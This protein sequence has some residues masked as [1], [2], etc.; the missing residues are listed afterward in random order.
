MTAIIRSN[1]LPTTL[2]K[3]L[4]SIR[5]RILLLSIGR[6]LAYAIATLIVLMIVSMTIDWLWG[7]FSQTLR[8]FLTG[9][10]LLLSI[11]VLL[12]TTIPRFISVTSRSKVA[13][14]V[15][16]SV[17][18]MQE[19]WTTVA[20]FADNR[21]GLL[22]D[23][24]QSML[25]QVTDEAVA[26]QALVR[27]KEIVPLSVLRHSLMAM[28]VCFFALVT[29]LSLNWQQTTVLLQRFWSPHR[30][31]TAT[32]LSNL[33]G[34]KLVPR[35][36]L[37][38][39]AISQSGLHR[40]SAELTVRYASGVEDFAEVSTDDENEDQ[41]LHTM[42]LDESVMYRV[43]AGDAE[44]SWYSFKVIDYPEIESIEFKVVAPAYANRPDVIKDRLPRRIKVIQGT[45][46]EVAIR[47]KETLERLVLSLQNGSDDG[48][49]E[50]SNLQELTLNAD[51]DG[52]YRFAT[53]LMQNLVLRPE[54]LSEHGLKNEAKLFSRIEV[55]PDQTP[56]ARV[57]HPTDEMAVT[58]DEVIDIQF[59]AHDDHGIAR[60]ELVVY[61]EAKL[62]QDRNPRILTTIPI[63][64]G[65]QAMQKHL[66]GDAQLDLKELDLKPGSSISYAVRVTDNRDASLENMA[67]LP[68]KASQHN[69][70]DFATSD[71]RTEEGRDTAL[72]SDERGTARLSDAKTTEPMVPAEGVQDTDRAAAKLSA[73]FVRSESPEHSGPTN[74]NPGVAISARRTAAKSKTDQSN[75]QSAKVSSSN[76]DEESNSKLFDQKAQAR[77]FARLNP[78]QNSLGQNTET[79]RRKL[80]I[81][82]R[83]SAVA[84]SEDLIIEHQSI[85]DRVV[86]I[87]E[88][89]SAGEIG[90]RRLVDHKIADAQRGAQFKLLDGQFEGVE[91]YIAD[92]R[93]ETRNNQYAFVGLQ[94]VD[95]S[96]SHITPARDRVFAG[97][98]NPN[99]SDVDAKIGLG[100][101]VR[102]RELLADLLKRYD[103]VEQDRKLKK[104]IEEAVTMYE[105]YIE[106][107]HQLMR[108]ARQ[109]R[110]PL[111]RSMA[112]VEVDQAYLDRLAEVLRLRRDMFDELSQMLADDPRLLSR[113]MDLVKR[114][115]RSL[116]DQLSELSQQQEELTTEVAG[117]LE[118]DE[119]QKEVLWSIITEV[120]MGSANRIAKE[121]AEFSE[122][123][124]KQMPLEVDAEHG[125]ASNLISLA[126]RA[127][128]IAR[129]IDL[130][131][132]T[133]LRDGDTTEESSRS[134]RLATQS[135]VDVIASLNLELDRFQNEHEDELEFG[136]FIDARILENQALADRAHGWAALVYDLQKRDYGSIV[137]NEQYRIAVE[138]ERLRVEML[139]IEQEL[140]GRFQRIA[141]EG[142]PE[143]ISRMIEELHQLMESIT[144]NQTAASYAAG[145]QSLRRTA[146]QQQVAL[147]RI[148][149]AED[150]FDII[151]RTVVD[152]ID[153]YPVQNP[154]IA[155]LRDP[156][157][158]DFLARLEREPNIAA[159]LGLPNRRSNLRIIADSM[160]WAQNGGQMLGGSGDAAMLRAKK[161]MKMKAK[162]PDPKRKQQQNK[163]TQAMSEKQREQAKRTQEMM[164]KS[165]LAIS[166]QLADDKID[167]AK[168]DQLKQVERE[169]KELLGKA[170]GNKVDGAYVWQ[171]LAQSDQAEAI[172]AA[173]SRGESIPDGQ[174]NK[175]LSSLE[176]GLWQVRGKKPPEEYRSAIQQYHD[177]IRQL[178]SIDDD[179]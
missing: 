91:K 150:L 174:W 152:A 38:T 55:I 75:P 137:S 16:A 62:D 28:F 130:D 172:M 19:R 1:Q 109:N 166:Q 145:R 36:E 35:G 8:L 129:S 93:N 53:T 67:S 151:R 96:R 104:S 143:K 32:K 90:L 114:R 39:V 142:V 117:W 48:E 149:E 22:S 59:E 128:E 133:L 45:Q 155:D 4:N 5:R 179:G 49:S 17:P 23:T 171:Q 3:R 99:A 124:V 6:S 146:D 58:N 10:T 87:D 40:D 83:L 81:A 126:K 175:L 92:L 41:F 7:L 25:G 118:I 112:I 135:L 56:V 140:E 178:T 105:V 9:A 46:L 43:R 51:Q 29:F 111:T 15:D 120:R 52:V 66:I 116:R 164:E 77:K 47:P 108:E 12:W 11:T 61:D 88:M 162:L 136:T 57:I 132:D 125:T 82:Q 94:M 13:R 102:A 127:A 110:N 14:M 71:P 72:A 160:L 20:S 139:G 54:L 103:K 167:P 63:E 44:T 21:E 153:E 50:N 157:L 173:I 148:A 73:N 147:R 34:S 154:N 65:E 123:M 78:Q 42:R 168:R 95:I 119:S 98:R 165:L 80:I 69:P 60:A 107:R 169:M 2:L 144:F 122:R 159:Q 18:Q 170:K 177:Q 163:N 37:V 86:E 106:K 100:S 161:A 141:E 156:T 134:H 89:L 138:T 26:M 74:K 30:Q 27:P 79:K 85:R 70:G 97:T 24:A 101:T 121:T 33:T 64:L 84:E 68:D 31:I 158:D 176:D 115:N 76:R 131:A 113:Y